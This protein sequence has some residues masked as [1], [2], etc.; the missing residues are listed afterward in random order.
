MGSTAHRVATPP[1]TI[2]TRT[3]CL[4]TWVADALFGSTPHRLEINKG[5]VDLIGDYI[6]GKTSLPTIEVVEF[7]VEHGLIAADNPA[8]NI[9]GL[10]YQQC[11]RPWFSD[12][13]EGQGPQLLFMDSLSELTDKRFNYTCQQGNYDFCCNYSD[14]SDRGH[15]LTKCLGML[16]HP[17]E[18]LWQYDRFFS[19]M[20][21]HFRVP[22]IFIH[23]PGCRETR[24][25][26]QHQHLIIR[27][28]INLLA[29]KYNIQNIDAD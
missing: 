23:F 21:E 20:I 12:R 11:T 22:I 17:T 25:E 18:L 10:L 16:E 8:A 27:A 28:A 6:Y 26:Y 2:L 3:G 24:P 7:M 5:R 13:P 14:L 1:H 15:L 9:P 4:G 29:P 19:Y